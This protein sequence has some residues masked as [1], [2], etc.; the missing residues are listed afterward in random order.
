MAF[1]TTG[2]GRTV[3]TTTTTYN[4][5]SGDGGQI[6]QVYAAR[7]G[8][9]DAWGFDKAWSPSAWGSTSVVGSGNFT[10]LTRD[11]SRSNIVFGAL[12]TGG[13]T[14]YELVAGVWNA[15]IVDNS[16]RVYSSLTYDSTN[17][18]KIYG[19]S[20]AGVYEV[21]FSGGWV[22]N[23]LTANVYNQLASGGT[24]VGLKFYG[25]NGAG[26]IDQISF[27][28]GWNVSVV[29][30]TNVYT[31]IVGD[32]LNDNK[33]YGALASGGINQVEFTGSGWTVNN[34][35]ATGNYSALANRDQTA[36]NI[37]G[38][39]GTDFN[40]IA[41]VTSWTSNTLFTGQS[42]NALI[43]DGARDPA[44]FGVVPEPSTGLMVVSALGLL[45]A[46]RRRAGKAC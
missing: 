29:D 21:T 8:G 17:Q 19:A 33:V 22:S 9:I 32:G 5:I 36:N 41:F 13:I 12:S 38:S 15:N 2:W 30:S 35:V 31:T 11:A 1:N 46:R 3:L 25:L 6:N 18:N 34:I 27:S 39:T 14:Q 42:Y 20:S 43:S 44:I 40:E 24:A 26:N 23:Q 7:S 10:A 37:Y 16:A 4:A 28:A 45:I